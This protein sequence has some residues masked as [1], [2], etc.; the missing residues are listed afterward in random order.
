MVASSE[1]LRT[2]QFYK[3]MKVIF[4]EGKVTDVQ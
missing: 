1:E 4:M 3:D 2:V